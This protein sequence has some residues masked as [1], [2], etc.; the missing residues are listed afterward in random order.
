VSR[1]SVCFVGVPCSQWCGSKICRARPRR[2]RLHSRLEASVSVLCFGW[3]QC[4]GATIFVWLPLITHF[5]GRWGGGRGEGG[6]GGEV[7]KGSRGWTLCDG[8]C[9][10]A[11]VWRVQASWASSVSWAVCS[12]FCWDSPCSGCPSSRP[13]SCNPWYAGTPGTL[14]ANSCPTECVCSGSGFKCHASA[15]LRL[16]F[17]S[18]CVCPPCRLSDVSPD[19]PEF[20]DCAS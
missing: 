7:E 11:P 10:M 14:V 13:R 18:K 8:T 1:S 20:C 9:V 12:F 3:V 16:S 5:S 15:T 17:S 2:L 6:G 19:S 4:K